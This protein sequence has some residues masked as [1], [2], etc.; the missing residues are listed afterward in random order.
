MTQSISRPT[1]S[2]SLHV[3]DSTSRSSYP[4]SNTP[5][6]TASP[7]RSVFNDSNDSPR[8]SA[9]AHNHSTSASP[10]LVSPGK[11]AEIP[12]RS[13]SSPNADA[14]PSS[15]F[16]LRE[17]RRLNG[18]HVAIAAPGHPFGALPRIRGKENEQSSVKSIASSVGRPSFKDRLRARLAHN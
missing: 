7:S 18:L 9:S 17:R 8:R 16:G 4:K 6:P 5:A 13:M 1:T 14:S 15:G 10:R 12:P 2:A 11:I 3:P